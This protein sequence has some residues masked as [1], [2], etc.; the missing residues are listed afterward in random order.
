[1][2]IALN[3]QCSLIESLNVLNVLSIRSITRQSERVCK[4]VLGLISL[5]RVRHE[6]ALPISLRKFA[7]V[8]P[9]LFALFP[10]F[11][12]LLVSNLIQF[13][14]H[15]P[16]S[17]DPGPFDGTVLERHRRWTLW[18]TTQNRRGTLEKLLKSNRLLMIDASRPAFG[19]WSGG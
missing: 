4:A 12:A 15:K 1:M 9:F 19:P 6:H 11:F 14:I 5:L 16:F 13:N 18:I 2:L 17:T 3:V 7:T 10:I 8:C